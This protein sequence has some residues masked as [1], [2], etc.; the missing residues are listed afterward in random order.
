MSLRTIAIDHSLWGSLADHLTNASLS[1]T[2]IDEIPQSSSGR[3]VQ[4][5]IR[6]SRN[7]LIC[8]ILVYKHSETNQCYVTFMTHKPDCSLELVREI[9]SVLV[10]LAPE[11]E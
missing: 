1:V 5:L 10:S 11:S 9:E 6:V 8:D 4:R 2:L 3:V 7:N